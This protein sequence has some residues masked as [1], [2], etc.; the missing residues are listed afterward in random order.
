V[1]TQVAGQA[2]KVHFSVNTLGY[3]RRFH[4]W[5]T[6]SE[7]AEHTYEGLVRS[8]EYFRG[9]PQDVLV[10]NQKAAVLQPGANGA[11]ARFN[12]RFL[13]LAGHYGFTPRACRP[14]RARTKGK[15]ERMVGY[16]QQHFFVRYRA[17]ESWAHL[18]QQAEHWLAEEADQ[19]VHGTVKEVVAE[20]FARERP[21]LGPLPAQRYNTAYHE[22][23][24]VAWDGYIE[25]RGNRYSVPAGLAPERQL[26][27]RTDDN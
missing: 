7:D 19:R 22:T 18:N 14:Y 2:V 9:V 13:D 10:D 6:D 11:P 4:F 3:S 26:E 27:L 15:D 5:C 12:E 24:H 20:R 25:V 17:F 16:I 8:F 21:A 23:R 1:T